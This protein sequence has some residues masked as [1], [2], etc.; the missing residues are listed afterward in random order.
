MIIS[1][2][3]FGWAAG[4]ALVFSGSGQRV[5]MERGGALNYLLTD[6]TGA[7]GARLDKIHL[8]RAIFGQ[9]H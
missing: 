6:Q 3:G 8:H 2:S 7:G 5:A 1:E 4:N 9:V